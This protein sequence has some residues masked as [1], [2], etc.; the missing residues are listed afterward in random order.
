MKFRVIFASFFL[1]IIIISLPS[2]VCEARDEDPNVEIALVVRNVEKV[3]LSEST[4]SV[5][6]Y[7]VL[8]V[9]ASKVS[10]ED[11]KKF[12]FVNGEPSVRIVD[13]NYY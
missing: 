5:D 10:V 13:E 11:A 3:D 12:E 2:V 6:F 4:F 7:L 9:D 1:F 8:N